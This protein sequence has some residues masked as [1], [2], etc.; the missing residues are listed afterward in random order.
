ME[1]NRPFPIYYS[2]TIYNRLPPDAYK[3]CELLRLAGYNAKI[4]DV[5]YY[6]DEIS[7]TRRIGNNPFPR[8]HLVANF[9]QNVKLN[10]HLDN[11]QHKSPFVDMQLDCLKTE[12]VNRFL[13]VMNLLSDSRVKEEIVLQIKSNVLF[14]LSDGINRWESKNKKSW[15]QKYLNKKRDKSKTALSKRA[16]KPK[17]RVNYLD[18]ITY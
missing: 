6:K 4:F 7:F 13:D 2:E 17:H 1:K 14:S 8:F 3:T 16:K 18:E 9:A 10:F 5:M 11:S 12:E 15:Y